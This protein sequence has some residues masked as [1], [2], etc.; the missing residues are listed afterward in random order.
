V[1]AASWSAPSSTGG[2]TTHSDAGVT[3]ID[4]VWATLEAMAEQG[5]VLQV[6]GEVTDSTV[7]V[8]DREQAFIDRVLARIVERVP[9]LRVVFEHVRP[10]R[11]SSSCARRV[12]AWLRR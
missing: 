4:N 2:A 9:R 5:L 3:S 6:H 10:R 12:P 7:D 1:R 8:F 11:P